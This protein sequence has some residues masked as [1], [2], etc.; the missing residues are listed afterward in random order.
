LTRDAVTVGRTGKST[1]FGLEITALIGRAIYVADAGIQSIILPA[2]A[3]TTIVLTTIIVGGVGV[4]ADPILTAKLLVAGVVGI[5][6]A[7]LLAIVTTPPGGTGQTA[8]KTNSQHE[9]QSAENSQ[10]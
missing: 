7:I 8:S 3:L 1:R 2:I 6:G 4:D 10:V 9:D 5:A